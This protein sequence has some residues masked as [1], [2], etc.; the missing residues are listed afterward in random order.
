[1]RVKNKHW[2][3][4]YYVTVDDEGYVINALINGLYLNPYRF[5]NKT[6]QWELAKVKFITIR[7]SIYK[8]G[9]YQFRWGVK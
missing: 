9:I 3:Y 4:N 7:D 5:N 8:N 1:M 2:L 6:K